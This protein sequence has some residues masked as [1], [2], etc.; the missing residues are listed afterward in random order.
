MLGIYLDDIQFDL[1]NVKLA[2]TSVQFKFKSVPFDSKGVQ[3]HVKVVY[4]LH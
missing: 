2:W 1:Q 4:D 3:I